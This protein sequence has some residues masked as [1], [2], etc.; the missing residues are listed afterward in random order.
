MLNRVRVFLTVLVIAAA[1]A[2]LG[3]IAG[4]KHSTPAV[5]PGSPDPAADGKTDSAAAVP[6]SAPECEP[7]SVYGPRPCRS[8]ADCEEEYGK[9]WYCNDGHYY[10]DG[11]G[12]RID[13]PICEMKK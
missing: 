5:E 11:C 12:G 4:C 8:D 6:K 1:L 9:G 2:L 3:F 10:D 7:N 13:W